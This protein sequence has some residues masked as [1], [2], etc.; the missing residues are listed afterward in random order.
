MTRKKITPGEYNEWLEQDGR[1]I[2][3]LEPYVNNLTKIL[4]QCSEGHSWPVMPVSI[5]RGKG[6]VICYR[7]IL[8]HDAGQYSEW[9]EQ[10]GR[11]IVALEPYVGSATKI[12]H[13]CLKGH[14]WEVKPRD[15]KAGKG[16]GDCSR[17]KCKHNTEQYSAWLEQDG[18]GIVAL[19]PYAGAHTPIKHQC[20]E[21]HQWPAVPSSI[22]KGTGCPTC[23]AIATDANVFYIWEKRRRRRRVQGR[24]HQ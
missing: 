3:A 24:H 12:L 14:Q 18:R 8:K 4:H 7:K 22:K 19:E 23:N 15:I 9:L 11:G 20:S 10:D 17:N 21:G 5:K 2:V 16:C 13:Q 6:C 1:G